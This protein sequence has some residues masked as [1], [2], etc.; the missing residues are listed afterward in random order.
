MSPASSSR[1]TLF[2]GRAAGKPELAGPG[3]GTS[4]RRIPWR[5]GTSPGQSTR[6]P[7]AGGYRNYETNDD[8]R[9]NWLIG[10]VGMGRRTTAIGSQ[11]PAHQERPSLVG[12]RRFVPDGSRVRSGRPGVGSGLAATGVGDGTNVKQADALLEDRRRTASVQQA[13]GMSTT[14]LT[15]PSTGAQLS[16][17]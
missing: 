7:C 11:P 12:A 17:M 6:D 9:N 5:S 14:P 8:S 2:P 10:V 3:L 13:L 1:L 16:S 15:R 4:S